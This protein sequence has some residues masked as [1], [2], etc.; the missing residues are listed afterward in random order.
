MP[1]TLFA[2]AAGAIFGVA[3]IAAANPHDANANG[4]LYQNA[5]APIEARVQDL[6]GKMTLEEKV[7]QMLGN[8]EG[9]APPLGMVMLIMCFPVFRS[10]I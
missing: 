8:G 10:V 5:T 2:L 4:A 6:V 9:Y 1:H 7:H 3:V